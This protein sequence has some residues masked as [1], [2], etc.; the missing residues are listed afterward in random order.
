M[1]HLRICA[2]TAFFALAVL[3][4][5]LSF[6]SAGATPYFSAQTERSCAFCH[7][8]PNGGSTLTPQGHA[9]RARGY[10]LD[11]E[12][13]PSPWR[14]AL[15]FGAGF[16]HIL[17]AIIWFGAI[18]Y[19]HLFIGPRSL[20]KGLPRGERILGLSGVIILAVTGAA[21]AWLRVPSWH[22]LLNT[23]FGIVLLFKVGFFLVMVAVAILVNTYVHRHLKLDA[24]AGAGKGQSKKDGTDE[25][26]HIIFQGMA[27]DVSAS[28]LWPGGQHMRR[29]SAGED[30]TEA[31]EA[32]PHG[33]EVLERLPSLG[34]VKIDRPGDAEELGPTAR[35][36]VVLA[37]VVL[38]AMLGVLVCLAWWNW[39][40][41]LANA[42]Q[43]FQPEV[44]RS[45]L[46]CHKEVS[47]GIYADWGK[48]RH[49][50]SKVSCLHCHQADHGDAD[51]DQAHYG[52][53]GKKGGPWGAA[54]YRVPVA[55]VVTPRDC[56]RCHPDEARQYSVSK[57]AN[58][59][60]IIWKIDPWLNFGLNSEAERATGCLRCHG[61][62]LALKD[63]KLDPATWPNVGVGRI[64]LDG[65]RG[66]CSSCHTRHAF[67][68]AEARKP[69][70]CGQCHLGP[71][72]PQMEIY[73]ES[74]HGAIYQAEG[75]QWLWDSAAGAWTPGVDYRAP[76]CAV[77]HMSGGGEVLT[78]HDVTLR[79]AWES[80]APLTIR[81][82]DFKPWPAKT[83]WKTERARMK[84]VCLRCHGNL[85]TDQH[86]AR[87][88]AAVALYNDTYF[89]PAK[90][91]L[92]ELYGKGLMPKDAFFK[93]P[94]WVEFYELWHHEGRRA[95]MGAAMMAPDYAW[96]H[97]FYE[98]KKRFVN[99]FR[100]AD[101]HLTSGEKVHVAPNFPAAT[102]GTVRPLRSITD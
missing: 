52:V 21:L 78:S 66:S 64:N 23:T 102:G 29:H 47:P 40:P 1:I 92:D 15:S 22:Y 33:P 101:E 7:E 82:S 50:H 83:D 93:A 9:F 43:P 35:L 18:F 4:A 76:S 97:G 89:K 39:G 60:E 71:D 27:Y 36:L 10:S 58:T 54:R 20:A 62:A 77:C 63:G 96:W 28:K 19:I 55:G 87:Y 34:P 85:W 79:L 41:P 72:H 70:A 6:T 84:K 98:C 95:R 13:G 61:A 80:Q 46:G 49:A 32:A 59:L 17:A 3:T 68:L 12:V 86:F 42:A 99:F 48:S 81:P 16:L 94:L 30:L 14:E 57:H 5:L 8:D 65:S 56:G 100:K 26:S 44:A 74:K 24:E 37:Y 91:K 75:R 69:E 38:A 73:K 45:C 31:M 90:A 25:P 51:I 2:M 11:P 67:S 53:Y 88:D